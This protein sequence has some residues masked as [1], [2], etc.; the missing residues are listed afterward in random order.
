MRSGLETEFG[1]LYKGHKSM[2]RLGDY[3]KSSQ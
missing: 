1:V 3:F 2:T